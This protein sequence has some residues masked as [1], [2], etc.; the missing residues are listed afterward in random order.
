MIRTFKFQQLLES[1]V[2]KAIW[3]LLSF[4][5]FKEELNNLFVL[6]KEGLKILLH[7]DQGWLKFYA[8]IACVFSSHQTIQLLSYKNI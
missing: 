5:S 3:L 1:K 8:G 2:T 4:I 7:I 6:N